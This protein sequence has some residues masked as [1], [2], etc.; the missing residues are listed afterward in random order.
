MEMM[1]PLVREVAFPEDAFMAA[2]EAG[3]SMAAD[4]AA[5]PRGAEGRAP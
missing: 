5:L 1:D 4:Q 3:A 2:V